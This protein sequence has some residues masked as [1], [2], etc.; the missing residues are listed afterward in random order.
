MA[1][2]VDPSFRIRVTSSSN[3]PFTEAS[4]RRRGTRVGTFRGTWKDPTFIFPR[5]SSR[6]QPSRRSAA[7]SYFSTVPCMSQTITEVSSVNAFD[8][9]AIGDSSRLRPLLR[10][11]RAGAA[12]EA[13][14]LPVPEHRADGEDRG[15]PRAVLPLE[16]DLFLELPV[17]DGLPQEPRHEGRHVLR[18]V[19]ARDAHL[20]DHLVRG[21]PEQVRR[22]RGV[23]RD[24]PL[25]V[26]RD[27]GRLCGEL[28]PFHPK[29]P[30]GRKRRGYKPQ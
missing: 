23:L 27:H 2:N 5:T 21:P 28:L 4:F 24:G 3:F 1:W 18:Q 12:H 15:E 9:A 26:A 16:R 17:L 22:V 8:P 10:P 25:H 6:V 29:S 11:E 13:D 7:A 20:P 30:A 19:E 14:L